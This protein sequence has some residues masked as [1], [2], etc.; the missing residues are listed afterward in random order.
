MAWIQN[1]VQLVS[2]DYLLYIPFVD[3]MDVL[4]RF[5][6]SE[7]HDLGLT[8]LLHFMYCFRPR[9]SSGDILFI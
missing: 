6:F 1:L 7:G 4:L 9:F 5:S 2:L 8:A 3:H